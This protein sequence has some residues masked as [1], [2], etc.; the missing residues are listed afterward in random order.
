[1]VLRLSAFL[2]FGSQKLGI[3]SSLR[4]F[5]LNR[6]YFVDV[7]SF[8]VEQRLWKLCTFFGHTV[9]QDPAFSKQLF[10]SESEA[11]SCT[12]RP[13]KYSGS[14]GHRNSWYQQRN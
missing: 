4:F 3:K 14:T 12:I 10:N 2:S 11:F 9:Q 5:L 13:E 1:M 8:K 7:C 6:T